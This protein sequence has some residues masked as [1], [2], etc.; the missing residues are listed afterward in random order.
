MKL[1]I[2]TLKCAKMLARQGFNSLQAEGLV[3]TFADC[4]FRNLYSKNEINTM[5]T[6]AM[7]KVFRDN[8]AELERRLEEQRRELDKRIEADIAEIRTNRRWIVG[9]IITVGIALAGYL[10]ALIHFTH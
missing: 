4:K 9:T 1:E 2:D 6:E 7:E 5:L 8:R 10:S 3:S